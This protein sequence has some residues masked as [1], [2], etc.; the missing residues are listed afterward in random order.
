MTAFVVY[1]LEFLATDPEVRVRFRALPDF[2]RSGRSGT[3][4]LSLVNT[5]EALLEGK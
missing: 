3:G 4:S 1:W 5:T 2:L